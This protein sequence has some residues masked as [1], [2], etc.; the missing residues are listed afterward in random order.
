MKAAL[1]DARCAVVALYVFGELVALAAGVGGFGL[2]CHGFGL[3]R[4]RHESR[5]GGHGSGRSRTGKQ[6]S[7]GHLRI[8][9]A[10]GRLLDLL[11]YG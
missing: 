3:G 1:S 8:S 6:A 11:R 5:Y 4:L 10:H 7:P 9:L 2:G